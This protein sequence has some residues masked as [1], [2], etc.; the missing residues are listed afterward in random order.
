MPQGAGAWRRRQ[1]EGQMATLTTLERSTEV[2]DLADLVRQRA[3][4]TPD[5]VALVFQ[6]RETT[7]GDLD[8]RTSRVANGLLAATTAPEARLAVLDK[9]SDCFFEILFGAVKA[10]HVPVGINWR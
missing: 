1:E 9:N 4:G 3:A 7:Y 5:R 2:Q 8:R 10:R 6:E